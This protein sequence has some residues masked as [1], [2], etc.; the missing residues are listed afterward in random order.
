MPRGQ[1]GRGGRGRG[2]GRGQK[3]A[4]VSIPAEIEEI[5]IPDLDEAGPSTKRTK[6]EIEND[7]DLS[8]I[9]DS[10]DFLRNIHDNDVEPLGDESVESEQNEVAVATQGMHF[11]MLENH[12][13]KYLQGFPTSLR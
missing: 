5:D 3:R 9:L 12:P 11:K 7:G 6:F 13:K 10:E 1:R 8:S 2:R 4:K